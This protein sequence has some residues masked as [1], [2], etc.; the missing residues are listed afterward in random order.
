MEIIRRNN[1]LFPSFFEGIEKDLFSEHR[2]GFSK[3]A[4]NIKESEQ[5]FQIELA[6]P[7]IEKEDV[8][9]EID[10]VKMIVKVEASD[11]VEQS[12]AKYR[13]KEFSYGAFKKSFTLPKEVD[14]EKI[15]ADYKKGIV[16]VLIPKPES[17][18]KV[19]RKIALK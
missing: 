1:Q 16:S 12:N 9:I 3:I 8:H 14:V 6:V 19:V 13:R 11:E 2:N 7:G 17:K 10:G 4:V 18:K 15:E 5:D